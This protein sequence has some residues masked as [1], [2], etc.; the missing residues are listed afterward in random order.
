MTLFDDSLLQLAFSL[1]N[2]RGAYALLLGSGISHAAGIPTGWEITEDL[3]RRVEEPS[4]AKVDGSW[5]TYYEEK[6][7]KEPNYSELLEKLARTPSERRAIIEQYIEPTDQDRDNGQKLPTQAHR[8]IAK[9]VQ[10]G[11]IEVIITTNFDRLLEAAL[12]EK[13]IEPTVVSKA[14]DIDG[15]GPFQHSSC[16]I[17]KLHGDY[18]D[19]N[20]LNTDDELSKYPRKTNTILN[21]ILNEYGL[22][23]CGWSGDWDHALRNALERRSTRRYPLFWA[24][25]SRLSEKAEAVTKTQSAATINI[26]GADEFFT[27]LSEKVEGL[28]RS[29]QR[30]PLDIDILVAQA[31]KY[32]TKD[33]HRISLAD[34]IAKEVE[35][36]TAC[37]HDPDLCPRMEFSRD[38]VLRR[39]ERYEAATKGLAKIAGLI[40]RWGNDAQIEGL[41]EAIRSI[42][43]RADLRSGKETYLKLLQY[44]ALLTYHAC[45]IG[46]VKARNWSGLHGLMGCSIE[47][48]DGYTELMLDVFS[49]LLFQSRASTDDENLSMF[50]HL[51]DQQHAQLP[52]IGHLESGFFAQWDDV[53]AA[54][55]TSIKRDLLLIEWLVAIDSCDNESEEAQKQ[56]WAA[57]W[58]SIK[59][60]IG[61]RAEISRS[62]LGFTRNTL[63]VLLTPTF[64]KGLAKGGFGCGDVDR[65]KNSIRIFA[66]IISEGMLEN[67]DKWLQPE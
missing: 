9:L 25:R 59:G 3:I 12:N 46:L 4:G 34:L 54:Q 41:T 63:R 49:P 42:Y 2:Q 64:L 5:S 65:I 18:R 6:Y 61:L 24:Y 11:Y 19:K 67:V 32:L 16:Y 30:N 45:V 31:K 39:I 29:R 43:A 53:F 44:P 21:R 55:S 1:H 17:L 40:G 36:I 60:H 20:I 66:R 47:T 62:S 58:Y 22:I 52:F 28:E 35:R 56:F 13:G 15:A 23:V 33:E 26:L 7:K 38:A 48:G 51:S 14:S 57:D 8:N 10:Q 37:L 27:E 50:R